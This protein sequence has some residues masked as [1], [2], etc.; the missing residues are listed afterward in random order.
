MHSL[1]SYKILAI[2]GT[3]KSVTQLVIIFSFSSHIQRFRYIAWRLLKCTIAVLNILFTSNLIHMKSSQYKEQESWLHNILL[4]F[5]IF[6]FHIKRFRCIGRLIGNFTVKIL[7]ISFWNSVTWKRYKRKCFPE[8]YSTI[9]VVFRSD[10]DLVRLDDSC[11]AMC[12]LLIR[13]YYIPGEISFTSLY[14]TVYIHT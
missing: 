3:R 12:T 11:S 8:Q 10:V 2:R 1:C 13:Y 14:C 6:S 5:Q 7:C 4:Q 9:S